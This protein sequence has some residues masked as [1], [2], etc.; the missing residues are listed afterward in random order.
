MKLKNS[1][2]SLCKCLLHN[3]GIFSI[4]ENITKQLNNIIFIER[5]KYE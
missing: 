3:N 2:Y 5:A 1:K 4:K